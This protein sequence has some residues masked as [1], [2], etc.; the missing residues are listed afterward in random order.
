MGKNELISIAYGLA[1][2]LQAID[3]DKLPVSDYNKRYI[4]QLHPA[5]KYYMEIYARCLWKGIASIG[6]PLSEIVFVDY[7]GGSGFLSMLAKEAGIGRII[8]ID[9]NPLSVETVKVLTHHTGI[10][11]DIILEGNSDALAGWC[12][13]NDVSPDL[14]VATDLI[15]HVYDLPVFFADLCRMNGKMEMIFTTASTP[16]NPIVKRRLR[17]LMKDCERGNLVSPDYYTRRQ[18][19]IRTHYPHFSGEEVNTW[20]E[21]TRGLMYEDMRKAMD[22]GRLPLPDDKYNTCDPETGNWTERILPVRTYKSLLAQYK[23]SVSVGKGFYNTHRT[24]A[25]VNLISKWV[26]AVIRHSGKAG[27]LLAPF[28]ILHCKKQDRAEYQA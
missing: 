1:V 25:P 13:D 4:R 28:I 19:F 9:L 7:G 22:T 5:L 23:Y 24:N 20:T 14:L 10:G 15:E 26:N 8:Y 12:T 18:Q 3:Y 16:Y 17:R 2:R 21:H 6:K 27:L 11:P